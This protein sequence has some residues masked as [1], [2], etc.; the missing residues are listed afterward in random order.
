MQAACPECH[1]KLLG[2]CIFLTIKHTEIKSEMDNST[3]FTGCQII[4]SYVEFDV[5]TEVVTRSSIVYD[6][7]S[8]SLLN[9]NRRLVGSCRF[10]HL[11][12]R[13]DVFLRNVGR[14]QRTTLFNIPEYWAK[15][16][17]SRSYQCEILPTSQHRFMTSALL[18]SSIN[19]TIS[20]DKLK[21]TLSAR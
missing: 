18:W 20:V 10:H 14:L 13:C 5:L 4:C 6:T 7:R 3:L 16:C 19:G 12:W 8:C 9:L 2:G 11:G 1:S 21:L 15:A 17:S